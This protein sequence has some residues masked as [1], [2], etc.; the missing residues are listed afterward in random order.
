[1]ETP[2]QGGYP[3]AGDPSPR[4][5]I[6]F[7]GFASPGEDRRCGPSD[8]C[9]RGGTRLHRA[10]PLGRGRTTFGWMPGAGVARRMGGGGKGRAPQRL[11]THSAS[12]S[13]KTGPKAQAC[14]RARH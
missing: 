5:P 8:A 7:G 9:A 3:P 14:M 4:I 11:Q 2:A 12:S 10:V 1:M 13:A 6:P